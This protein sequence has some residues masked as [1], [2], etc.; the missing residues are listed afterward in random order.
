MGK[1]GPV[2]NP[3]PSTPLIQTP[4]AVN[5]RKD[6]GTLPHIGETTK[7]PTGVVGNFRRKACVRPF[8]PGS[9]PTCTRPESY[10]NDMEL[11][12]FKPI[13][14]TRAGEQ[15]KGAVCHITD[16]VGRMGHTPKA[17]GLEFPHAKPA[18]LLAESMGPLNSSI[19]LAVTNRP[20]FGLLSWP[21]FAW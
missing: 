5:T 2:T 12:S 8:E 4:V 3:A 14:Y 13:K 17:M 15:R 11:G 1:T 21:G 16:S 10:N 19:R 20:T 18:P 9:I 6:R 7:G